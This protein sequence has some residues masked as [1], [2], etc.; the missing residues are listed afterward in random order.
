MTKIV[1]DTM[2][3]SIKKL[4]KV[5]KDLPEKALEIWLDNTPEKSGNARRKTRL[6][7]NTIH[8]NYAYAKRLNEGWS[9]KSPRGISDPTSDELTKHLNSK[10]RK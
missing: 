4:E 8:A 6:K 3:S 2:T 10:L 5:L 1:K 9:K 7:G